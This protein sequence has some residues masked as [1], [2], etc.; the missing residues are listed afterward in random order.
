MNIGAR[1]VM[2]TL[3]VMFLVAGGA[4][5]CAVRSKAVLT[6]TFVCLA[7]FALESALVFP[8]YLAYFN[9]FADGPE[10]GY[11]H[12]VDSSLDWGQDLPG[13]QDWLAERALP[14]AARPVYLSYFG[15]A[16]PR[17]WQL[18]ALALPS[19]GA[20]A[21]VRTELSLRGGVYCIS[22][23]HLQN[24]YTHQWGR[25]TPRH[26]EAFQGLL[27]FARRCVAASDDAQLTAVLTE[28][29]GE[30]QLQEILNTFQQLQFTRLVGYLRE[31]DPLDT[32]GHSILVYELT[33]A[34][35]RAF[36]EG[37]PAELHPTSG[38]VGWDGE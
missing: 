37:P 2:L 34:D 15:T 28:D 16:D 6:T 9:Q 23:T 4:A 20:W 32:I 18:G 31:R 12:L 11:E 8:H 19:Y 26:E 35:V 30:Q 21:A 3:P 10:H 29:G 27:P 38:L 22:A 5:G 24:V 17:H 14:Q 25:W 13:L 1:H 33:D 7:L 36:L